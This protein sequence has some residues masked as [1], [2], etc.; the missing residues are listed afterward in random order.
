M[1]VAPS[2]SAFLPSPSGFPISP[3]THLPAGS[4]EA[5][6]AYGATNPDWV[7]GRTFGFEVRT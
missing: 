4:V 7:A 6:I 1:R 5:Q 3:R 2:I